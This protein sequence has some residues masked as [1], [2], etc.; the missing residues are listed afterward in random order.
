[1][2]TLLIARHG[3]TFDKGDIITRVGLNTDIP[4][5]ISGKEQ[6]ERLG[7]Y[8]ETNHPAIDIAYGSNLKRTIQTAKIALETANIAIKAEPLA[9]FDEIDYG[10]DENKPEDEVVKRLG[11]DA[12]NLWDKE[13]ITPNGWN[14]DK[15]QIK[16]NWQSFA[17]DLVNKAK[18][19]TTLVV[20]SN[21]I[22]RFVPYILPNPEDF[23]KNNNIKIKT[24]AICC[25][26]YAENQWS[27]QYWNRRP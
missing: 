15:E 7:Q 11:Q 12:L 18:N 9:I 20:T 27:A 22:A 3:N 23:I 19:Q 8:L 1:M 16:K 10:I 17:E 26:Q 2:I 13:A 21:G 5:S 14:V 6:A 4:L 25:L 24:G